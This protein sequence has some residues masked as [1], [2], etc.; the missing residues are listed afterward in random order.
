MDETKKKTCV[1]VQCVCSESVPGE[2]SNV[3]CFHFDPSGVFVCARVTRLAGADRSH[4]SLKDLYFW[5]RWESQG[6]VSRHTETV[7]CQADVLASLEW[8]QSGF[9]TSAESLNVTHMLSVTARLES[10]FFFGCR[11]LLVAVQLNRRFAQEDAA[12]F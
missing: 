8:T 4:R 12:F 11:L 3:M 5:G 7:R 9:R 2:F 10:S 6:A 1:C